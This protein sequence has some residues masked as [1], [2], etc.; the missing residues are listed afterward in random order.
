[1]PPTEAFMISK[2]SG[3]DRDVVEKRRRRPLQTMIHQAGGYAVEKAL[4]G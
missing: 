2:V 4:A 3:A 1:M